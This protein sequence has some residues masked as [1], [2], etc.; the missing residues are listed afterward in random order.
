MR[1][2][3]IEK[4]AKVPLCFKCEFWFLKE[5]ELRK[6]DLKNLVATIEDCLGRDGGKSPRYPDGILIYDDRW[7]DR[8]E[9]TERFV[10]PHYQVTFNVREL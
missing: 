2:A 4:F 9:D 1:E 8:Y 5:G 3:G 7:I 10:G 6:C